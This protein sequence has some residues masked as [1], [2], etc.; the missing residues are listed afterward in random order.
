MRATGLLMLA[1]MACGQDVS[2]TQ[3][4][5]C[6]GILQKGEDYV[7]SAFDRDGDGFFDGSNP[8][9]Q[10]TYSPTLLDCNDSEE[11]INP[12]SPEIAC[13]TLDNDCNEDT[14][15]ALDGDGD[16]WNEC[17]DCADNEADRSPGLTEIE[18]NGIDDDCDEETDDSVDADNDGVSSCD[19]C[20]DNNSA[21]HPGL[22]EQCDDNLDNDCDGDIDED[23]E[24]SDYSGSYSFDS[25][26]YYSC[27]YGIVS[28]TVSQVTI[29]DSNPSVS[30]NGGGS[31]PGIMTGTIND[32]GLF[33]AS[34]TLAG[35]CDE[36]YS[37]TGEFTDPDTFDATMSAVFSGS[38]CFDCTGYSLDVTGS[39]I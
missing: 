13:D 17:E 14:V 9:C 22:A 38:A 29:I 5:K 24:G 25:T 23:C 15:D 33:S 37:I 7:D 11:D 2:V 8:D 10:N 1:L 21:A 6:D 16:G 26:F 28:V 27:A 31:Q 36:T 19:D 4:A 32:S 39:R 12:G 30:V 34:R 20:N 18:C 35:T 3:T